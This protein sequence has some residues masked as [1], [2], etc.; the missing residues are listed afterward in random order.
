MKWNFECAMVRRDYLQNQ[1]VPA[2]NSIPVCIK[3]DNSLDRE[4]TAADRLRPQRQQITFASTESTRQPLLDRHFI[5]S[6]ISLTAGALPV[7][8]AHR[9]RHQRKTPYKNPVKWPFRT[10]ARKRKSKEGGQP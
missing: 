7:G 5:Q 9:G 1:F 2:T 3:L 6:A 4:A 10:E 8:L